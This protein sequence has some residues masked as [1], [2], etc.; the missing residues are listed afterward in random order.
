MPEQRNTTELLIIGTGVIAMSIAYHCAEAGIDVVLLEPAE[1]E[2]TATQTAGAFRTYFPGRVHDSELV[3]RSLDDFRSFDATMGADLGVT[4]TGMLVVADTPEQ[5]AALEAELPA[6]REA[7]V[8]LEL[9]TTAVAIGRN[10]WLDPAD[11][12]AAVWC[13]QMIHL[14]ADEVLRAYSEG[15]RE[16]GAHVLS[17]TIATELDASTGHV[18]TTRADFTAEAIVIAAGQRTSDIADMAGLKLPLWGQYAELFRTAPVGEADVNAPFTFHPDAGLKTMGIGPSFL[19]GLE[20]FSTKQG[21]RDIWY[22]AARQEVAQRY[23]RLRDVEL[24]S[25]WTGTLDVTPSRTALIGKAGG[26]HERILFAAGFTGHELGQ[27]PATG[28][29]IRDLHLGR[30]P[31]VDITPFS[32]ARNGA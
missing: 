12:E 14:R 10:P 13:P 4:K 17:N 21:M 18:G 32:L 2:S 23:P 8:Q 28:K 7:G 15:A 16:H 3:A 26:R 9:L 30:R 29:I 25:A 6:Q 19:V 31:E 24:H 11:V 22:K 1:P 5:A 20:R 27:A